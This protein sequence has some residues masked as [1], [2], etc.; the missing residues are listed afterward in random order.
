MAK[1]SGAQLLVASLKALG[2]KHIFSL[3]GT[4]IMSLLEALADAPEIRTITVRHE[5]IAYQISQIQKHAG[6]RPAWETH[7]AQL[8]D[9]RI[10]DLLRGEM[11]VGQRA[12]VRREVHGQGLLGPEVPGPVDAANAV[13]EAGRVAGRELA[14]R[15]Q[16]PQGNA[17]PQAGPVGSLELAVTGHAGT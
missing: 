5:Q 3:P 9:D 15:P 2:V 4:G 17:R 8:V 16:H 13:I 12:A 11:A 10:L 14:D 1:Q 6:A 7:G